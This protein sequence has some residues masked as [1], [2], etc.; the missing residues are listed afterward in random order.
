MAK[1]QY[2]HSISAPTFPTKQYRTTVPA[3]KIARR[4]FPLPSVR[5]IICVVVPIAA[6]LLWAFS[7]H[8]V[9]IN[10]MNDLGL[11][12]VMPP[13][14][15]IAV[16]L[17]TISYCM[18]LQRTQIRT[19]ILLLHFVFIIIMLYGVTMFVEQ[20]PRF[21]IVY[22]HAGYT[23]YIMRTGT[24]NT[25]L[26][27]YFSWPGFF[28]LSAVLVKVIGYPSILPFANYA[29][30]F[31][32]ILY[33]CASYILFTA[34]TTDKRI[35]WFGLWLFALTNW[36]G[37][38]YFSP[39]GLNFFLY[40]IT[41]AIM[42]KWFKMPADARRTP[43]EKLPLGKL[44]K[45]LPLIPW[46]YGWL[47]APDPI[48]T[49]SRPK[50]K[51]ALIVAMILIFAFD[52]FSHPLTPFFV[53]AGMLALVVLRR[54]QLW[55]LAVL[56]VGMEVFWLVFMTQN[57]LA[58]NLGSLIAGL[59]NIGSSLQQNVSDRVAG[60]PLHTLYTQL[61]IM[62]A[63]FVWG[64]AAL[65]AFFRLRQ[66]YK[67]ATI[68]VLCLAPF[69]LFAM[70]QYGGEMIFRI[71]LFALPPMVFFC[72]CFFYNFPVLRIRVATT[73]AITLFSVILLGG[74]L[75]TRYGNERVNNMTPQEVIG[76]QKLYSMGKPNSFFM[77]GWVI[78]TPWQFKDYEKYRLETLDDDPSLITDI[79]KDDVKSLAKFMQDTADPKAPSFIIFTSSEEASF[80]STSG[81][82]PGK[83]KTLD[84]SLGKS[85]YFKKVFDNKDTQ[86]YELV[87][88][89][90][91]ITPPPA[92]GGK[93][94]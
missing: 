41:M 82:E 37:Q 26:D 68:V 87:M 72:A 16:F 23:E 83:L 43:L 75:V 18:V 92:N 89:P 15:I 10:N 36:I 57:Y 28:A 9:N 60:D 61:C 59:G 48:R 86:I 58:G 64:F 22:R 31:Y 51:I 1:S 19:P 73:I 30:I 84:L 33:L 49:E 34:F 24:S 71:Y 8:A 46:F 91:K 55:W 47:R 65:G 80:D 44:L 21:D 12:S 85:P 39:Q 13:T 62:T 29:P 6:F 79:D 20:E 56:F 70:G 40:L 38:D 4:S 53:L 74:F 45:H 27:A 69:P 88:P 5:D 7:L 35:I 25:L 11:V 50:Q 90:P 94:K 3:E 54:T 2:S 42:V 81:L 17:M 93:S 78:G 14:L 67:D 63:V 32:N 76:T 77:A 52:V 66:G